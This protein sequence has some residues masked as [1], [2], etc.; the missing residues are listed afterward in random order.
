M[1]LPDGVVVGLLRFNVFQS[2]KKP[3]RSQMTDHKPRTMNNGTSH[4]H[5]LWSHEHWR[6]LFPA[7]VHPMDELV[8][9]KKRRGSICSCHDLPVIISRILIV[10]FRNWSFNFWNW[11][12]SCLFPCI[13]C[14]RRILLTGGGAPHNFLSSISF[15]PRSQRDRHRWLITNHAQ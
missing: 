8:I 11:V 15:S 5:S 14:F 6:V 1:V 10:F 7:F 12:L 3:K 4:F 13:A 2:P 9:K